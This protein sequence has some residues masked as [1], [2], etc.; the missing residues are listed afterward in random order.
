MAA[1][2]AS[3][4]QGADQAVLDVFK[5]VSAGN[6]AAVWN[7]MPESYQQDVSF[8]VHT[9]ATKIDPVVWN[10]TFALAK[11][12]VTV[13]ETKKDMI[14]AS[15]QMANSPQDPEKI[16]ATYDS[17][18][19]MLSLLVNSEISDLEKLKKL[20]IG[21]FAAGTGSQLVKKGMEIGGGP[22]DLATMKDAKVT[23]VGTDNGVATLSIEMPDEPAETVPFVQ[24]EGKWIPQDM[25][26]DWAPKMAEAKA[27]VQAMEPKLDEAQMEQFV[28][29]IDM[30]ETQLDGLAETEDQQQFNMQMMMAQMSLM[31]MAAQIQQQMQSEVT[32]PPTE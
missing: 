5:G 25:A 24:V 6:A 28:S 11:K 29:V 18:V 12:L 10:K 8:L 30:I 26:D 4:G 19:S 13:L 20:D 27:K 15:P 3:F 14:L 21:K 17:V 23:L 31:G 32:E 22:R 7:A 2:T 1:S 16:K 9:G